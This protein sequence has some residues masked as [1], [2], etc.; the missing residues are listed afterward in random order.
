[1][2][3]FLIGYD[4]NQPGTKYAGLI[5]NIESHF[6]TRWHHLDSTWLVK[7]DL[8]AK[9]IRDLL[10]PYIDGNDKLLVVKLTGTGAWAGYSEKDPS[11][12]NDN[13]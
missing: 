4:L 8:T 3:T 10:K 9:E 11:W 5:H 2:A 12:I 13:F 1:M 6:P 7:S